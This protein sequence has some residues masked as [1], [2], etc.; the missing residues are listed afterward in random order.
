VSS[1]GQSP[2]AVE[3][4]VALSLL[5]LGADALAPRLLKQLVHQ[6]PDARDLPSRLL[7]ALGIAPDEW[8]ARLSA[9]RDWART[10]V[11]AATVRD[12][13]A[14]AWADA[15]YPAQ[16]REIPDPPIV[17]W[18]RGDA[19]LLP[20]PSVA[21]V[22]SRDA[23][24]SGVAAARLLGRGLA[25]AGLLIVSGLARGID[26]AA[27]RGALEGGGGTVG[28]LGCGADVTYPREHEKLYA[29]I[30]ERGALVTELPPGMPP[31]PNHFPLRNRII[32]GLS[33]AVIV[34][35]ASE[36]S[37]SLITA[38]AALDQGRDVLVVPG[39]IASGRYRGSHA[40]IKDGAPLV[41]TVED[42]LRELRWVA[43]PRPSSVQDGKLF[44][45]NK[46]G[47]VMA[48]GET[49]TVDDLVERTGMS[50]PAVLAELGR[51]E[52]QGAVSRFPGGN[53][54]RIDNSAIGGGDA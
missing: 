19:K 8:P 1:T 52:V 23:T 21:I 30:A 54:V 40:L 29:E 50:A 27:H 25:E 31:L 34:I 38:K 39:G 32:S 13:H 4:A 24:P 33:L 9:A 47:G 35:E 45:S 43:P 14:I 41:E 36:K 2:L 44:D 10:A 26:G 22:G 7:A 53:F 12:I 11:V 15:A 18:V 42:V 49:Y 6:A 48:L 17:L 37:G 5:R 28:V 46:L 20:Q 3:E 51:L 16:L